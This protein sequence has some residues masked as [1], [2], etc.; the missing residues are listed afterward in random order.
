MFS[1]ARDV[2]KRQVLCCRGEKS[3]GSF[4]VSRV[5]GDPLALHLAGEGG[6]V[7]LHMGPIPQLL[8]WEKPREGAYAGGYRSMELPAE[9]P[10]ADWFRG[11]LEDFLNGIEGGPPLGATISDG[12]YVDELL[13]AALHSAR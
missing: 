8:F 9:R 4:S 2:Y 12:R 10:F 6:M 5:G 3:L 1:K 11:E 7:Q 13:D